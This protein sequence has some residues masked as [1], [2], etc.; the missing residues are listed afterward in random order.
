MSPQDFLK[1]IG[2]LKDG[3]KR[4]VKWLSLIVKLLQGSFLL[5]LLYIASVN[6][7]D[8][9]KTCMEQGIK[10]ERLAEQEHKLADDLLPNE[11][12]PPPDGIKASKNSGKYYDEALKK[13]LCASKAGNHQASLQAARLMGSGMVESVP[14]TVV[15]QYFLEAANAEIPEAQTAISEYYCNTKLVG[16]KYRDKAWYWLNRAAKNKDV[17]ALNGLGATYE[18][19][20][21]VTKDMSLAFNYYKAAADQGYKVAKKN[22]C[23]LLRNNMYSDNSYLKSCN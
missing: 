16:C 15:E 1:Q 2:K 11:G 18:R 21:S 7:E 3:Y 12:A 9:S 10:L 6:A 20:D 23:R 14:D 8:L 5:I 17:N 13:Y 4:F 22:A 19:G